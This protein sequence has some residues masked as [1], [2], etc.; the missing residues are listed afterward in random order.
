MRLRK[1]PSFLKNQA[2]IYTYSFVASSRDRLKVGHQ[3]ISRLLTAY[4]VNIF[5]SLIIKLSTAK[6]KIM[7]Q[8]THLKSKIHTSSIQ[9]STFDDGK[10]ALPSP[11]FSRIY[12]ASKKSNNSYSVSQLNLTELS[13]PHR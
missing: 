3:H 2:S 5:Y 8:N 13:A 1:I 11:D 4:N 9:M 6:V 7:N 12:L 10:Y